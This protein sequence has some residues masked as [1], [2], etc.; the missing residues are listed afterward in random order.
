[1][2]KNFVKYIKINW[3]FTVNALK[4]D[5]LIPGKP[6]VH[7]LVEAIQIIIMLIFFN[8]IFDNTKS[9]GGWSYYQTLT[10]YFLA[11]VM[12]DLD[13]AWSRSGLRMLAKGLVRKGDLDFFLIKPI[14]AMFSVAV[15]KPQI[16]KYFTA[17]INLILAI[18]FANRTGIVIH[19]A[20]Y[21][22]FFV[23][24]SSGL[25]LYFCLNL[26]SLVPVFWFIRLQNL[27]D[28]IG[29]LSTA[30]RYPATIYSLPF[31]IA[32]LFFLPMLVI[33]YIPAYTLF[34]PPRMLYSVYALL[35]ATLFFV[36]TRKLW[37][38]GLRNYSS[39]S[40]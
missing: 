11:R 30:M 34:N 4:R 7:A 32:F 13:Q 6:L 2:L 31:K 19:F 21:F 29:K 24:I 25:I 10:M 12:F 23:L 15:H 27:K 9:I 8:V 39:A 14:D 5:L 17:V 20:N 33:T 26:I 22:W 38:L 18:I 35:I 40:S 1:M 36:L 3:R 16:Y 37:R 28:I